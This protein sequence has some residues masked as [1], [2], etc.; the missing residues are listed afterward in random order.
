MRMSHGTIMKA[1]RI[2]NIFKSALCTVYKD[3]YV[4]TEKIITIVIDQ[5]FGTTI[6]IFSYFGYYLLLRAIVLKYFYFHVS[7]FLFSYPLW[8]QFLF[9]YLCVKS[10][11]QKSFYKN[12]LMSLLLLYLKNIKI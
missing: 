2:C 6:K 8:R 9:N 7:S 4:Y 3:I 11:G 10:G 12:L 5:H 1:P